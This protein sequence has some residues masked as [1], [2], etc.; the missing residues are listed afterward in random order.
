[1]SVIY[2]DVNSAP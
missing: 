2:I 1:M